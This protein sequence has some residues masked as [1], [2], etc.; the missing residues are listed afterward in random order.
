MITSWLALVACFGVVAAYAN[1]VFVSTPDAHP[2]TAY[3]ITLIGGGLAGLA[4]SAGLAA[5]I[6]RRVARPLE[7][8]S[9]AARQMSQGEFSAH[10]MLKDPSPPG[11]GEVENLVYDFN[12]MATA[13]ERL[14]EERQVNAAMIAHELRTPITVL[15]ARLSAIRDGVL[16]LSGEEVVLLLQRTEVLSTLV[17]DL[18]TLSLVEAGRLPLRVQNVD[19]TSLARD[20]L[21]SVG[22]QAQERNV[23]LVFSSPE[24]TGVNVDPERIQQVLS[25][26]LDNALRFTPSGGQVHLTVRRRQADV[27]LTVEDTGPGLS[28]EA[29][30][31]LF[32]RYY[33]AATANPTGSGLGLTVV[34]TLVTL[35]GGQV[36]ACNRPGGG[37]QLSFTLPMDVEMTMDRSHHPG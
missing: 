5:L 22:V 21:R 23:E 12:Q 32:D 11:T 26:L 9:Q 17:N 15:R 14:E 10:V 31:H 34:R 13:L 1:E 27:L 30:E 24:R 36:A 18:R 6:A 37:A 19:L 4:L 20:A 25:N 16:P 33:R 29:A 8:V 28:A 7:A 2:A 35:H 3:L